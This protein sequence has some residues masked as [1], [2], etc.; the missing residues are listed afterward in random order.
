MILPLLLAAFAQ[1]Q[2]DVLV[3]HDPGPFDDYGD[4]VSI[5]G[6]VAIVGAS[7]KPFNGMNYVG[8]AYIYRRVAGV[9]TEEAKLLPPGAEI[10]DNFG[11]SVAI[12][13]DVA[14]V[15]AP[16]FAVSSFS[17]TGRAWVFRRIA[18]VWTLEQELVPSTAGVDSSSGTYVD[19]DGDTLVVAGRP[20]PLFSPAFVAVYVHNGSQ[21][22]EEQVIQTPGQLTWRMKLDLQGDRLALPSANEDVLGVPG[23]GVVYIHERNAGVWTET[24]RIA[25]LAPSDSEAFGTSFSLDGDLIAIGAPFD[26][27]RGQGS[28]GRIDVFRYQAG[29]WNFE[30]E[31]QAANPSGGAEF[32]SNVELENGVLLTSAPT[33]SSGSPQNRGA[34][35][36]YRRQSPGNWVGGSSF[37]PPIR[38]YTGFGREAAMSGDTVLLTTFGDVRDFTTTGGF[39]LDGPAPLSQLKSDDTNQLTVTG[40]MPN[41]ATWL[42]FSLNGFGT[43][44]VAAL[45]V[46]VDLANPSPMGAARTTNANGE[47]TFT[48]FIPSAAEEMSAWWQAVQ[49]GQT[50]NALGT[51]VK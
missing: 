46:T 22:V 33:G 21:W 25:P 18:G 28:A 2:V 40:A 51:Y 38:N 15:G 32:G 17:G 12:Q 29:V 44:Q 20:L 9:W 34:A 47:T 37:Y 23:A 43:F 5:D 45:G 11:T 19:L 48:F 1:Q 50:S 31:I 36:I 7:E 39:R 3:P 35:Q 4:S 6:D 14:V 10:H 13:G 16:D 41:T 26:D 30:A 24:A 42:A 27:V 49:P 8:A